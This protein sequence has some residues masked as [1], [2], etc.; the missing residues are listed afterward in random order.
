MNIGL[1]GGSSGGGTLFLNNSNNDYSGGT[2]INS[3]VL[4]IGSD[5]DPGNSS[6]VT[7][8]GGT[9]DA[10]AP[11]TLAQGVALGSSVRHD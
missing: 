6:T 1:S 10:T 8:N 9:L 5:G 11:F 7:I 2:T 3:G 4:A